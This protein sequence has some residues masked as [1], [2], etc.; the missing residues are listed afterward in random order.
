MPFRNNKLFNLNNVEMDFINIFHFLF[1]VNLLLPHQPL[2]RK[3]IQGWL[4]TK[5]NQGLMLGLPDNLGHKVENRV[6]I[7]TYL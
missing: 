3:M 7:E 6:S 2:K 1:S 5:S 4:A